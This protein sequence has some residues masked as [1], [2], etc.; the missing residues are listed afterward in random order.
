MPSEGALGRLAVRSVVTIDG[1]AASGKSS[2]ARLVAERLGVP[3][4]SSGLLY[5]AATYL[6]LDAGCEIDEPVAVLGEIR[7]HRVALEPDVEG[8]RLFID[9]RDMTER[10]HTHEVDATVSTVA[11]HPEVREWVNSR[12]REIPPPFVV[13]GRDMGTVVFPEAEHKF[14]L[15][16]PAAVRARRRLGERSQDLDAVT[17]ALLRRDQLDAGRL[18]MAIDANSIDTGGLSLQEVVA[19]VLSMLPGEKS[20]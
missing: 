14:Y 11:T 4:V 12:L 8:N 2:V 10:L 19:E 16:A 13:E 5:R 20:G 17:A 9:D 7:G 3:F 6:A 15:T 18:A 1:P